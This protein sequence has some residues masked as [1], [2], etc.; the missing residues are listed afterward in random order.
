MRRDLAISKQCVLASLSS[1]SRCARPIISSATV[2]ATSDALDFVPVGQLVHR[3][4]PIGKPRDITVPHRV[5][6]PRSGASRPAIIGANWIYLRTRSMTRSILR[7]YAI[8]SSSTTFS[9][10]FTI[11]FEGSSVRSPPLLSGQ[12]AM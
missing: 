12:Y 9:P 10:R 5:N 11:Q 2:L 6:V 7:R 1:T 3:V 8:K 4:C